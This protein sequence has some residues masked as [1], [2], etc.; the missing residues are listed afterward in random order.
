MSVG[1]IPIKPSEPLPPS[2]RALLGFL[3]NNFP[4]YLAGRF[5]DTCWVL[6]EK[7]MPGFLKLYC[8]Q[9]WA[10]TIS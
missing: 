9:R 10:I 4:G 6:W 3:E 2:K 1:S 8:P 5:P 7:M